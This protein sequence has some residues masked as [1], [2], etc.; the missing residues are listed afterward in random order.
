[1]PRMLGE[2]LLKKQRN[3][4]QEALVLCELQH[5][6]CQFWPPA[7]CFTLSSH[8]RRVDDDAPQQETG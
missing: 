1:M 4:P 3:A 7:L 5:D 6:S 8:R 2:G